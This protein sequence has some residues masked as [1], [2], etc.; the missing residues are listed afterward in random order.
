[1]VTASHNPPDYNGMKFVRE[2]ARPI[3]ADTGL[4]DM[5]ALI[6]A[7]RAARARRRAPGR[8]AAARHQPKYLE[9]LL[10]YVDVAEAAPAQG[11]GE[12]RQRR[13]GTDRRPAR[14]APAVRV[15]EGQPRARRHLSARRAQPD[16][17][18]EPRGDR[19]RS[20]AAPAPTSASPG[21]ATTTAASSSTRPASSSRATTSS[22]C[23]PRSSCSRS[24]ARASCTTRASP[25]TR[26]TSCAATA[27][28]RC[29]ASPATPSSS[30][31][32]ARWMPST[33]G[34]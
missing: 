10:S 7:R 18:G 5:R 34:R 2:G 3:S 30:R 19:R 33:A 14:A 4:F 13:R 16:A 24:P 29:C 21:T 1:M 20:C 12:R 6:A 17:G 28:R 9:H 25:G 15:R 22:A 32:C 11:G 23:S 31:R 26:S 27:A 8:R